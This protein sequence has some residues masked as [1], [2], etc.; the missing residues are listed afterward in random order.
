MNPRRKVFFLSFQ[1]FYLTGKGDERERG[2]RERGGREVESFL[3]PFLLLSRCEREELLS[4]KSFCVLSLL[5]L[6]LPFDAFAAQANLSSAAVQPKPVRLN[7][8]GCCEGPNCK[9]KERMK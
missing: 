2:R 3:I 7:T 4:G 9:R 5:L 8:Q 1:S 6:F